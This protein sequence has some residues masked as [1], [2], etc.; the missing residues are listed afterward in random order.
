M[1]GGDTSQTG[2][3]P[4]FLSIATTICMSMKI[5]KEDAK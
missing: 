4:I 2:K 3:V 5:K 1:K